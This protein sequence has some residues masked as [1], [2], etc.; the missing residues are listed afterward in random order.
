LSSL[1]GR[2]TY[3][4]AVSIPGELQRAR[5]LILAA[6]EEAA[7]DVLL[8]VLPEIEREERDDLALEAFA[9]LGEPYLNP[10]AYDGTDE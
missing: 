4:C 8:A 7:K 5:Q 9:L 1:A 6:K 3:D 2:P 10:T